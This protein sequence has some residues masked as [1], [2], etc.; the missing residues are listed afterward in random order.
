MN[1]SAVARGWSLEGGCHGTGTFTG[2]L[3]RMTS[4]TT[5]EPTP[6]ECSLRE[7]MDS[8]EY[9]RRRML[10]CQLSQQCHTL[11]TGNTAVPHLTNRRNTAAPCTL[12]HF[13][14][15]LKPLKNKTK[16]RPLE[17]NDYGTPPRQGGRRLW[18][19]RTLPPS[20]QLCSKSIL[21]EN[22]F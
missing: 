18:C 10:H 16:L 6:T 5:C 11:P 7:T 3:P 14:V 1:Q 19:A 15:N 22:T 12:L 2:T 20:Q 4:V 17:K 21:L 13:S 8:R 9:R